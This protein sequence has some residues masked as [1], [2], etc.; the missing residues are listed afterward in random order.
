MGLFFRGGKL[1]GTHT[2]DT[3]SGDLLNGQEQAVG[4]HGL[5]VMWDVSEMI[6]QE[7]CQGV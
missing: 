3:L 2:P 1:P 4:L 6:I 7:S 5:T